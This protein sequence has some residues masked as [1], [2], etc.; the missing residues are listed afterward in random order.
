[1][2]PKVI[3]ID[4][5]NTLICYDEVFHR[6]AVEAG[7]VVPESPQR[8]KAVREAARRSPEGDI[9]WQRL[10]GL[11]YGPRIE[12]AAPAQGA[13][14]F[15]EQCHQ[16]GLEVHIISHKTRYAAIDP[17]HT[18]L[19]AAA[20]A[21][22]ANHGFFTEVTGLGPASFHC[23]T[24]RAQKIALIR[25]THCT[26]FIDDLEETFREEDFPAHVQAILYAPEGDPV[27]RDLPHLLVARTWH[28]I[29][30]RVFL[31]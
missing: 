25:E 4:F 18:D 13:L 28:D 14:A 10:Q 5:D 24:T 19:Q 11:A 27:P 7:L 22:L 15:L 12:E 8:Q 2:P 31:G 3:G 20:R 1:M 6:L 29:G 16:S 26:H 9:A 17:S 21:W 30:G 23:G